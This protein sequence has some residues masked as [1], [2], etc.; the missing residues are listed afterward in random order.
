MWLENQWKAVLLDGEDSAGWEE[1]GTGGWNVRIMGWRAWPVRVMCYQQWTEGDWR[2]AGRGG[3]GDDGEENRWE[4]ALEVE[5]DER[6]VAVDSAVRG[7]DGGGWG[8]REPV[9]GEAV[10]G[11]QWKV[12]P[13][14]GEPGMTGCGKR[15]CWVVKNGGWQSE[16]ADGAAGCRKADW[17]EG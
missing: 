8:W 10:R 11:G 5:N 13:L 12:G 4:M 17:R 14:Q 9:T 3:G 7:A 2:T 1:D 16:D 15:C 6:S